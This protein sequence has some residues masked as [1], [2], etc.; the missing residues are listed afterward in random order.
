ML[1]SPYAPL[2][3]SS[4][5][6]AWQKICGHV[7]ILQGIYLHAYKII[8]RKSTLVFQGGKNKQAYI[9]VK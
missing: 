9:N 6:F 8:L 5:T 4:E 7:Q 3:F 2:V 1:N